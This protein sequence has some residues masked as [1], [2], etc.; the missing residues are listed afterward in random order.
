MLNKILNT[1][2]SSFKYFTFFYGYLKIKLLVVILFSFLVSLLD[3]LSISIFIPL[4]N[5]SD[6]NKTEGG[7]I[8]EYSKHVQDFLHFLNIPNTINY[9]LLVML[10]F[11]ILKGVFRYLDVHYR[12]F[13]ISFFVKAGKETLVLGRLTPFLDFNG[14]P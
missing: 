7:Q 13:L 9:L 10:V 6:K 2:Q 3:A 1:I 4:L 14:P 8:D 12:V 5:T 11:F